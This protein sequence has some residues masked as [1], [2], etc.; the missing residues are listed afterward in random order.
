MSIL[1]PL[2]SPKIMFNTLKLN[3]LR[4]D[5]TSFV[6]WLKM[7]H[8][9]LISLIL[10][11][12]RLIFSQ[13]HQM[14]IVDTAFCIHQE[15][16]VPNPNDEGRHEA[17]DVELLIVQP[18]RSCSAKEMPLPHK[19]YSASIMESEESMNSRGSIEICGSSLPTNWHLTLSAKYS[20]LKLA[21]SRGQVIFEAM[22][23]ASSKSRV[24]GKGQPTHGAQFTYN[25][26]RLEKEYSKGNS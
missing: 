19:L 15:I 3:I 18:S 23:A 17:N 14:I 22:R 12:K 21:P 2:I 9:L 10:M 5:I 24:A 4:F 13:N 26:T 7:A 25:G 16:L 1:V 6:S 8:S 20:T 11:I